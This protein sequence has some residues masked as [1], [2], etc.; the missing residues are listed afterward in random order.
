MDG[1]TM[2]DP[3]SAAAAIMAMAITVVRASVRRITDLRG[4]RVMALAT[5]FLA[6][7]SAPATDSTV[8]AASAVAV[9]FTA[10]TAKR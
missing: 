6:P 1:A 7:V 4:D 2:V 8:A 10:A 5:T 9:V 3:P